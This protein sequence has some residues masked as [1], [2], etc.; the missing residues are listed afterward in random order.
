EHLRDDGL[1][2]FGWGV[3]YT[4]PLERARLVGRVEDGSLLGAAR[5]ALPG[6]AFVRREDGVGHEREKERESEEREARQISP[7]EVDMEAH[8]AVEEHAHSYWDDELA[9]RVEIEAE[10]PG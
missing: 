10:A 1:A 7:E 2:R 5:E 4:V 3:R 6:R 8:Q 9:R